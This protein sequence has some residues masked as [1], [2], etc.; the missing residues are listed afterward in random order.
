[1]YHHYFQQ[2]RLTLQCG[3]ALPAVHS[4]LHHAGQAE[5]ISRLVSQPKAEDLLNTI[6]HL[7]QAGYEQQAS[8]EFEL[9]GIAF[10][11]SGDPL[12]A[13]PLLSEVM[14]P[15]KTQRHGV[16]ITLVTYGLVS[17]AEAS[18]ICEQLLALEV[19]QLEVF[20]P[21]ANPPAYQKKVQ[22]L[23]FGFSEVCHFIHTAAE[24]GLKVQCFAYE[25]L[26]HVAELRALAREL[27]ALAFNVVERDIIFL[28]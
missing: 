16:P 26:A 10:A 9:K 7:Y 8:T 6:E 4:L 24:S 17:M 13:L 2:Q 25:P 15:V 14:P 11:G 18:A 19:E 23:A 21:A 28:D 1:M 20:L 3:S 27:G 5:N 12:L 22:P